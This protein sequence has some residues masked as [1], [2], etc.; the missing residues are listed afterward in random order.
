MVKPAWDSSLLRPIADANG[1]PCISCCRADYFP[2]VCKCYG[3]EAVSS[4]PDHDI[5]NGTH[6]Q[7]PGDGTV[8]LYSTANDF[9]VGE[10]ICI[11]GTTNFNGIHRIQAA[12]TEI[13]YIDYEPGLSDEEFTAAAEAFVAGPN[14]IEVRVVEDILTTADCFNWA[15]SFFVETV[16]DILALLNGETFI[17]DRDGNNCEWTYDLDLGGTTDILKEWKWSCGG[18]WQKTFAAQYIRFNYSRNFEDPDYCFSIY[19]QN[20][21]V[22][23]GW[24]SGSSVSLFVAS[25]LKSERLHQCIENLDLENAIT[26]P[27]FGVPWYD[28]K[29]EMRAITPVYPGF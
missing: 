18:T 23:S 7:Y 6:P 4:C 24:P 20:K 28:G 5:D 29:I 1:K 22:G 9:E 12:T 14:Q 17:L 11:K 3:Y 15:G 16:L 2:E 25:G 13:F 27:A 8:G 21:C 10:Y 26:T 19:F